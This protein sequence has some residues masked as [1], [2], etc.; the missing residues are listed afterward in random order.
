MHVEIGIVASLFFNSLDQKVV[1]GMEASCADSYLTVF[2]QLTDWWSFLFSMFQD[3]F[4]ISAYVYAQKPQL[5]IHSFE[6]T[7]TRVR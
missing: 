3:L 6:G 7:F 5:D 4:S 1:C 2:V